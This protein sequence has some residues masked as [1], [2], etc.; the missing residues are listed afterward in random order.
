MVILALLVLAVIAQSVVLVERRASDEFTEF[1]VEPDGRIVKIRSLPP[2][3]G[4]SPSEIELAR[5]GSSSTK[6]S[7]ASLQEDQEVL[8]TWPIKSKMLPDKDA[9][10]KDAIE[11]AQNRL[12]HDLGLSFVPAQDLIRNRMMTKFD[13]NPGKTVDDVKTVSVSFDL[14][15]TRGVRRDLAEIERSHLTRDR[16]ETG[17]RLIAILT[18]IFGCIAGYI[19]LDEYTK[20]YY[21]GRLRMLTL[22]VA[23]VATAGIAN[24]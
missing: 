4:G 1:R 16:M 10:M 19:R 14:E 3:F 6:K 23:A 8:Q 24:M 2:R 21:T 13:E 7:R 5:R 9:A 15:L 20:G 11:Q 12:M 18:V 17:A 22:A